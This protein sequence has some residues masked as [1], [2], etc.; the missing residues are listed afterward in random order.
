MPIILGIVASA[1][2]GNL[3]TTAYESIQTVTLSSSQANIEFT[4]IPATFT[5]LQIRAIARGT[6]ADTLDGVVAQY[7]SDT[8]SNYSKHSLQGSGST[9]YADGSASI[10]SM[11]MNDFLSAANAGANIFSTFVID[12]L[13][14]ANTSKYKTQRAFGGADLNGSGY[15]N[16][17]SGNWRNTNAITSIKLLPLYGSNFA[18]YSSFALYGIKGA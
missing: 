17:H 15:V 3:S 12:I 5:H 13:D 11:T 4:S 10:A 16:L 2:T 14:Y 6:R 9:V 1:I 7:N 18:Q 8:G